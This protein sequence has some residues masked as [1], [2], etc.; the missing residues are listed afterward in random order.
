MEWLGRLDRET[1]NLRA[2][3][4]WSL[5][6]EAEIAAR[7][8]WALRPYWWI[9]GYHD[10]GRRWMEEALTHEELP[11]SLRGKAANVAAAMAYMQGDFESAERYCTESLEMALQAG[12]E[13]REGYS[14]MGLGLLALSGEDFNRAA[15]CLEKALPLFE[16]SE[17]LTSISATHVWLGTALLAQND[18]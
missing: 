7:L 2:A 18:Q 5:E 13:L 12:D 17:E 8:G 16:R 11:P 9:R 14:W 3:M 15:S 10:E 1:A 4:S 6:N